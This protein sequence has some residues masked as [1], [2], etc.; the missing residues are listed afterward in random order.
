M[1]AKAPPRQ[2][3]VLGALVTL[4]A[5]AIGFQWR[6]NA[7]KATSASAAPSANAPAITTASRAAADRDQLEAAPK[8]RLEALK[9]DRPEPSEQGRNLFREKPK[10]PPPPPPR[11]VVPVQPVQPAPDPN[12]PPPPPPPPPPIPLKL[13]AIVQGS[14]RPVAGLTDGRDVFYGC[15]GDNIEGRYKIIKINVE[16]VDVSYVDGRGQLRLRLAR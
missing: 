14:G 15:E 3:M 4:L 11:P 1:P 10:P 8:V 5:V 6:G 2:L 7:S 9:I 12:A 16:S 13:L